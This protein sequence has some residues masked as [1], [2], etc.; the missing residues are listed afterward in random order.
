MS[1]AL[2]PSIQSR[3][4]EAGDGQHAVQRDFQALRHGAF[5]SHGCRRSREL[6]DH[7]AEGTQGRRL[8]GAPCRVDRHGHVHRRTLNALQERRGRHVAWLAPRPAV[9][10]IQIEQADEVA[11]HDERQADQGLDLVAADEGVVDLA[12]SVGA[13]KRAAY[14]QEP[15]V[16]T[17]LRGLQLVGYLAFHAV[18]MEAAQLIGHVRQSAHKV[19]LRQPQ[20][21][22]CVERLCLLVVR[23]ERHDVGVADLTHVLHGPAQCCR[24]AALRPLSPFPRRHGRVP[25]S[26]RSCTTLSSIM[27]PHGR[28]QQHDR[29]PVK[30]QECVKR[31][32]AG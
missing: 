29:C 17:I 14:G 8:R 5:T 20:G 27:V 32:T 3:G 23:V 25:L 1:A 24:E 21:H 11:G 12:R 19:V 31:P 28:R 10:V 30:S 26:L 22:G 7:L 2:V 13:D 4:F 18:G 9:A 6:A 16:W 15:G